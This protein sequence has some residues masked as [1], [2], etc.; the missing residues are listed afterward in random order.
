MTV[1]ETR[2]Q[3]EFWNLSEFFSIRIGRG[4]KKVNYVWLANLLWNKYGMLPCQFYLPLFS[5]IILQIYIFI[6]SFLLKDSRT[7]FKLWVK[8]FA[9]EIGKKNSR[10]GQ[11][12]VPALQWCWKLFEFRRLMTYIPPT[13][14]FPD[15]KSSI[16]HWNSELL[17]NK[18]SISNHF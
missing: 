15:F 16:W 7:L 14:N 17:Y 10:K 3:V 6:Y 12:T 11:W 1:K 18:V 8:M 5:E 13:H 9:R 4:K 2:T